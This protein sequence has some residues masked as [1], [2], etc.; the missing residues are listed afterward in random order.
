MNRGMSSTWNETRHST[1]AAAPDRA[2]TWNLSCKDYSLK[3]QNLKS[4][5]MYVI[6]DIQINLRTRHVM[7]LKC[8]TKDQDLIIFVFLGS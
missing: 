7:A 8:L 2:S 4:S 1:T 3:C 6:Y 5:D